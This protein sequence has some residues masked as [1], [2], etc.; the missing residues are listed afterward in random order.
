MPHT[1]PD[2]ETP[3]PVVDLD[4]LARNLDRAADYATRHGLALRPQVKLAA[5]RR[6]APGSAEIMVGGA[7]A[8]GFE[9]TRI[10]E[11]VHFASRDWLVVGTFDA[12]ASGFDSEIWG[13]VETL[14]QA[15]RRTA[16]SSVV[17]RLSSGE[18]FESLRA[19]VDNDPR[20]TNEVKREQLFYSDQSRALST[21]I[22]VL[23]LTLTTVFSIGAMLGAMITMYAAVANRV[24]EI[25]TLRAL[26]FRR[27]A[28]LGAFLAEALLL[29]LAGG[30][31]GLAA[32]SLMQF[33]SFSTTNFQTFADL[34]FRFT[35]TPP[36]VAKT[37][38][39]ALAMGLIG[40]FLPAVRAARL[41]IV[42]ALRAS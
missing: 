24:T 16:F 30:L 8:R 17:F 1:I 26:G 12:G 7:I 42:D 18:R 19:E 41:E 3:I 10:G 14:M 38:A 15:F 22:T 29:G 6:F 37:I 21:F 36:I 11:K 28:I 39:F 34:A 2:L 5:G 13:D 9:G 40:G 25:G 20:L 31:A 27:A 4:R 35:L 32:A 23:G 33:A